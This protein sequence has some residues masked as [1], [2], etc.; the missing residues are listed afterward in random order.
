MMRCIFRSDGVE[1]KESYHTFGKYDFI[2]VAETRNEEAMAR[3]RD[4]SGITAAQEHIE[5]TLGVILYSHQ[6]WKYMMP[7]GHGEEKMSGTGSSSYSET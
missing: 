4:E 5:A 7:A 1:S 3:A 6:L 2:L